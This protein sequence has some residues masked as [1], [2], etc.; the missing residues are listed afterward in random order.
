MWFLESSI[1]RQVNFP[2]VRPQTAK[3]CASF[4]SRAVAKLIEHSAWP[5][6]FCPSICFLAHRLL[7]KLLPPHFAYRL[8][9]DGVFL[10]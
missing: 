10:Y 8:E 6:S 4:W 2:F 3:A 5:F 1:W 9:Q 7:S